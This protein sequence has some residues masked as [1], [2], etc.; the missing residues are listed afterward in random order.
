VE[1]LVPLVAFTATTSALATTLVAPCAVA[2]AWLLVRRRFP[3]KA[4]VETIV[5]LPLVLPPV[6]TGLVL[7]KLLGRRGPVGSWLHEAFGLD[8][9]FTGRAVVV[10]MAV[11]AFPL[12]VLTAR[13]AFEAVDPR[14]EQVAATLGA[15]PWRAFFTVTLPLAWP[16]LLAAALLAF[17]RALGEFGA[18]MLVAG[19][20]PGRTLTLSTAIWQ[21]VQLGDDGA[22]LRLMAVSFA[23]ALAATAGAGMLARRTR[24]AR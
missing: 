7:L 13:A 14:L 10:A 9:A 23:L 21:R 24:R 20:I 5:L 6:A 4:V 2:L 18:T 15:S 8:V 11:M 12:F 3:G 16:G 17:A 1:S 22:A 19:A